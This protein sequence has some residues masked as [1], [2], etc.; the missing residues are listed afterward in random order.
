MYENSITYPQEQAYS[1][2]AQLIDFNALAATIVVVAIVCGIVNVFIARH[3][4][5]DRG[6]AFLAGF[7]LLQLGV[8]AYMIMGKNRE[9]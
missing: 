2:S 7:L 3:Y 8:V 1:N 4:G 9:K 6:L 5:R